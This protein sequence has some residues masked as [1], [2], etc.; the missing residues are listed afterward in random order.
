MTD[1]GNHTS[2]ARRYAMLRTAMGPVIGAAL[3]DPA[4]IEIMVNPD[5]ALWLDRHGE[6]RVHS[7][8]TLSP[9]EAERIIRL[10]ASHI[11]VEC[12]ARNPVVSAELPETGERFEGLLPPVVAGPTFAIRK[13]AQLVYT[14]DDYVESRVMGP[15]QADALKRAVADRC[16]ILVAGGTSSGHQW[17]SNPSRTIGPAI[18]SPVR[19]CPTWCQSSRTS[20]ASS[21]A[22]TSSDRP[23]GRGLPPSPQHG[24]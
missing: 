12:H 10:V 19:C 16:N 1:F 18:A 24:V 22:H 17:Y 15:L 11:H 7:G 3:E 6:G 20:T 21:P 14:L 23:P 13:P 2:R 9:A 4:V 5:G 8:E